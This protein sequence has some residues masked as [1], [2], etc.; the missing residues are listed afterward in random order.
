MITAVDTNI[1][2]DVIKPDPLYGRTSAKVLARCLSEGQLL[3]SD[4]TWAETTAAF[5]TNE[6]AD[7]AIAKLGAEYS[8]TTRQAAGMAAKMWRRYRQAGGTRTRVIAD[9][10]IGAHALVCA[11]RLLTR[12]R[13]F[14]RKY[15]ADLEIIDP[16]QAQ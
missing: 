15:F 7:N 13:G 6:A 2:I 3:L 1:L 5:T 10:L 14:F 12:D 11:D 4:V 8:P 9:F 16:S